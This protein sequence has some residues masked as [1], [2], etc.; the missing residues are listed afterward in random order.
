VV[1][2]VKPSET[3][4]AIQRFD[5]AH[6]ILFD[7]NT[8]PDANLLV[9][10]TGT[11]GQPPGPVGFLNAAVDAGYRVISLAYNNTPAINNYCPAKLDLACAEKFRQMRIY[12]DGIQIDRPSTTPARNRSSI[13]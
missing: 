10:L 7:A 4:R 1:E 3:D 9:F 12:G 5:G 13:A 8:G 2:Q 11:G 6:Y